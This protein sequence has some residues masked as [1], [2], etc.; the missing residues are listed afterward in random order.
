MGRTAGLDPGRTGVLIVDPQNDF[1]SEGG[2]VWDLV[3]DGVKETKVVEHLVDLRKAAGAAG[4]PVFYSPHY[5]TDEEYERWKHLNPIDQLMFDRK[6]FRSG[7]WG[8]K[9]HPDLEPDENTVV[10]A[11]HKGL[12]NFWTG[13]TALQLRQR[14]IQTI[15]LAGMSANLCVES[16]LRDATENG[17]DVIV[18][19]D[20]TTGPGPEATQAAHTNYGLIAN[21]V[22]TT[23]E[24]ARRLAEATTGQPGP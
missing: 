6:M 22:A 20:A 12:S 19:K 24:V 16:H 4:V 8:A 21:E 18:V 13:D 2:A 7:T 3:G 15:V 10:L 5:Y 1:L 23:E 9:F 17:F 14:G 11:P